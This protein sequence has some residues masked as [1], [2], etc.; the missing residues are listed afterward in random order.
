LSDA[1]LGLGE[2][3]AVVSNRDGDELHFLACGFE[4]GEEGAYF[5][6]FF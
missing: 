6:V 4:G 2:G 5:V 1:F 3:G